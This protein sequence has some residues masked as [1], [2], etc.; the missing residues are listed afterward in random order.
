MVAAVG[1]PEDGQRWFSGKRRRRGEEI[2]RLRTLEISD[3]YG[4][5][6]YLW[7][8]DRRGGEAA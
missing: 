6:A 7:N 1:R 2:F 8:H 4:R 5:I 3:V